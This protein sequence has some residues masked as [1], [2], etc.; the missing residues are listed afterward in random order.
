MKIGLILNLKC[1]T[2]SGALETFGMSYLRVFCL[3]GDA[4]EWYPSDSRPTSANLQVVVLQP[5][6]GYDD[7]DVVK[8]IAAWRSLRLKRSRA[9]SRRRESKLWKSKQ[10]YPRFK[11]I[12]G[13]V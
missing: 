5:T 12:L 8:A 2:V 9:T 11:W 13:E 6:G 3:E 4:A 10:G 7:L 1:R